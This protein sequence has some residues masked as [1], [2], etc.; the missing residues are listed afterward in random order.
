MN[1]MFLAGAATALTL[2]AAGWG[3][4]HDIRPAAAAADGSQGMS[5]MSAVVGHDGALKYGAGAE[6]AVRLQAGYHKVAF[7]RSIAQCTMT[8][9]TGSYSAS[10]GSGIGVVT[11]QHSPEAPNIAI[12]LIN[13]SVNLAA[14]DSNFHMM[15]F[16]HK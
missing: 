12:V 4:F 1:R 8:G 10:A 15:V 2:C 11:L 5:L 16:C 7:N 6:S 14:Y 13:Y 3:A 9:N